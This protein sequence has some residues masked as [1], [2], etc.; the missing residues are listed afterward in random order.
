MRAVGQASVV[1]GALA[2]Y[3]S[4][5]GAYGPRGQKPRE[6]LE[7]ARHARLSDAEVNSVVAGGPSLL[8]DAI[9]GLAKSRAFS[10]LGGKLGKEF[11]LGRALDNDVYVANVVRVAEAR[12]E[13]SLPVILKRLDPKLVSGFRLDS[14]EVRQ[15]G[16]F[17]IKPLLTA[18]MLSRVPS[19]DFSA[20]TRSWLSTFVQER[21]FQATLENAL[22]ARQRAAVMPEAVALISYLL[23]FGYDF[24]GDGPP[25]PVLP[26]ASALIRDKDGKLTRLRADLLSPSMRRRFRLGGLDLR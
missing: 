12:P 23:V 25:G 5:C 19:R 8:N 20:R 13:A 17:A 10:D 7:R 24:G 1:A 3:L 22:G 15:A 26:G 9:D 2:M 16:P 21:Q 11:N 4:L 6:L 18:E 14:A